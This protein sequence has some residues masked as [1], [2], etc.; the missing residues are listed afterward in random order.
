MPH[1]LD[2]PAVPR[3]SRVGHKYAVE[4]QVLQDRFQTVSWLMKERS[5]AARGTGTECMFTHLASKSG[6]TQAHDHSAACQTSRSSVHILHASNAVMPGCAGL[7]RV[8][9]QDAGGFPALPANIL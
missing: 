5:V 6:Q 1:D 9:R 3:R 8:W 2:V 4:R 7:T